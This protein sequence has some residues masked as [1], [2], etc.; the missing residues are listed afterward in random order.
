MT[1]DNDDD[2]EMRN[3]KLSIITAAMIFDVWCCFWMNRQFCFNVFNYQEVYGALQGYVWVCKTWTNE[4]V[5]DMEVCVCVCVCVC[6][7][8][9][10]E[11]VCDMDKWVC[12]G[13]SVRGWIWGCVLYTVLL[14]LYDLYW[15]FWLPGLSTSTVLLLI[16]KYLMSLLLFGMNG[17][18]PA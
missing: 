10:N 4:C 14:L 12:G 15:P 17:Q 13:F 18:R 3:V 11:C 9:T 7:T 16:R 8:W 1:D 6:V 5:C 2:A